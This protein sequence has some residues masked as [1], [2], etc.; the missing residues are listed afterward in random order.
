MNLPTPPQDDDPIITQF[1]PASRQWEL[2]DEN[3]NRIDPETGETI[4]H[5]Y[6]RHVNTTPLEMYQ[7]LIEVKGCDVNVQDK[8]KDT[9]V[10]TAFLCF[11]P[12]NGGNITVLM[13]LLSQ[14]GVNVN[15]KGQF[16]FTFLHTACRNI[17]SLPI[18]IFKLLIE[19]N[20]ADINT[21][22]DHKFT[23]LHYAIRFSKLN[24]DGDITALIYLLSHR[25]VDFSIQN[26]FCC[27][28][29]HLTC[30]TDLLAPHMDS[31]DDNFWF[32]IVEVIAERLLQQVFEET[33]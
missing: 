4:L 23:P 32:P 18:E 31:Q 26:R 12:N 5:N 17:N 16:G 22:N 13:Y 8:Y 21:Q 24:Q 30:S 25:N 1:K 15:I 9:P 10:Y 3:I 2:N 6:C 28:L 19:I 27:T 14:Q 11:N 29:L 7:Y 33:F 20:G